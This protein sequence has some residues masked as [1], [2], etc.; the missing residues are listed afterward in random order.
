M[1]VDRADRPE[2]V[3]WS[4]ISHTKFPDWNGTTPT[5]ELRARD[6]ASTIV[7]FRHAGLVPDLD[8]Y[9]TCARGWNHYLASLTAYVEGKG[10]SPYG[11]EEWERGRAARV[12]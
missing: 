4:C 3:A 7:A 6:E 5:F 2:A 8:C 1:R 12:G 11:S 9:T 10:G